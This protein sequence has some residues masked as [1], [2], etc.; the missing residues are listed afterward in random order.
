MNSPRVTILVPARDEAADIAECLAAVLAQDHRLD[1]LEVVVIDGASSDGTATIARRALEAAGVRHIVLSNPDATTPSNLN[2]GLAEATGEVVCRVDA[3]S[4]IP[5][6]YVRR[7]AG[8]LS[9]RPD[10]AVV[11]GAQVAVPRGRGPVGL[12]I[13]RALN[14]RFGMGLARYRRDAASGPSDTVY[15]GAFRT[16]QLRA[17]G[18]WDERFPSNQDFELNRRMSALGLVWFDSSLAVG[19]RPRASLRELALQYHRFGRSKVRYWQTTGDRPQSRQVALLGSPV[20]AMAAGA[21]L[22][23]MPRRSRRVAAAAAAAAAVAFE[24]RG[25]LGPPAPLKAH[26]IGL[27]ASAIVGGGWTLG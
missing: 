14:N 17:A 22:C 7:C 5:P 8:V 1:R 21:M 23:A 9:S 25:S 19:Y 10:V 16:D 26:G 27:L 15:L 24:V 4:F 12:G 20:V 2:V 6:D 13:A 3:R 18:G 11:G